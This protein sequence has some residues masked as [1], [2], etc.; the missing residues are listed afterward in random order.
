MWDCIFSNLLHLRCNLHYGSH[1]TYLRDRMS[2][3]YL[4]HGCP[5]FL[6]RRDILAHTS[7]SRVIFLPPSR[8]WGYRSIEQSKTSNL[9]I[10]AHV[11]AK[12]KFA[13]MIMLYA[14]LKT[15]LQHPTICSYWDRDRI[16]TNTA[17]TKKQFK[18]NLPVVHITEC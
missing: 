14:F 2:A 10:N 18:A 5:N 3:D 15:L 11:L 16:W 1:Q 9:P 7:T 12:S 4:C 13:V 8:S 6:L 17:L